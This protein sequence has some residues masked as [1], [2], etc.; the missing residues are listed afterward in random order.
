MCGG[1]GYKTCKF[2]AGAL[3]MIKGHVFLQIAS[4]VSIS[5]EAPIVDHKKSKLS[6]LKVTVP[7]RKKTYLKFFAPSFLQISSRCPH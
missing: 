3:R 7:E 2:P 4:A 5:K 6:P 1:G